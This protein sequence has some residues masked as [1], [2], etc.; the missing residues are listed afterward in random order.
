MVRMTTQRDMI[1]K[2]G[3]TRNI[4]KIAKETRCFKKIEVR[5]HPKGEPPQKRKV[6]IG[7][8]KVSFTF[9]EDKKLSLG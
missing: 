1:D 9:R 8:Q 5:I 4:A 2:C 7:F 6:R 3:R